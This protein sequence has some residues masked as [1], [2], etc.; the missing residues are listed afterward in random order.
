MN[1]TTP[2]VTESTAKLNASSASCH[3]AEA[4]FGLEVVPIGWRCNELWFVKAII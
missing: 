4:C 3:G 2:S 1:T